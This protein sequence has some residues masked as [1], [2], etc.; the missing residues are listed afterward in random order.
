MANQPRNGQERSMERTDFA[1][2]QHVEDMMREEQFQQ[3]L[4]LDSMQQ[5]FIEQTDFGFS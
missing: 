2:E 1:Y 5:Q 4:G 3:S